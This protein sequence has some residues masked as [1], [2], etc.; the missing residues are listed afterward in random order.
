MPVTVT[1]LDSVAV[2]TYL[3]R[4]Y[5]GFDPARFS[6]ETL[7]GGSSNPTFLLHVNDQELVLRHAPPGHGLAGAHDMQREYRV[8][9]ALDPTDVPVPRMIS[10]CGDPS[11]IGVP[12]YI[13]TKVDGVI[14]ADKPP[15]QPLPAGY[16]NTPEAR[17]GIGLA[18]IDALV[19][20]H[21]VDYNAVG[22]GSFGRPEGYVARQVQRW[23][24]QWNTW[25]TRD[26]AEM[27]DLLRRLA[28]FVPTSSDYTIVHGDFRLGNLILAASNPGSVEAILDWEMATLGDPISDLG[29][30]MVYWG[31]PKDP[32]DR[33]AAMDLSEITAQSGFLSR[34]ELIH[35]YA[36]RT[37]RDVTSVDFFEMLARCKLAV[38]QERGYARLLST[39]QSGAAPSPHIGPG[40]GDAHVRQALAVGDTSPN[41]LL[42]RDMGVLASLPLT[43]D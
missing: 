6:W 3:A 1:A 42:R 23:T 28:R 30:T 38:F 18:L 21:A 9:A 12:F 7:G 24:D 43:R 31:E 11:V 13:M 25:K 29:Y 37:G 35:E 2:S 34:A 5:S 27:E 19:R 4:H 41:R 17:K 39:G 14:L 32:P 15:I 10:L 8:M 36:R 26:F 40:A 22:L 33:F 20:L 16:A